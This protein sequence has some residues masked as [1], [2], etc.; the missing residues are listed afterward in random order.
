MSASSSA[1]SEVSAVDAN[2]DFLEFLRGELNADAQEATA[3][4]GRWL[5]EYRP[6]QAYEIHVLEPCAVRTAQFAME[7]SL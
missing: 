3:L 6:L 4:L 1:V 7:V 5:V 2:P